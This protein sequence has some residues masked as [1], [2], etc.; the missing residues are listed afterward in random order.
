MDMVR[1]ISANRHLLPTFRLGERQ[2]SYALRKMAL[3]DSLPE[4]RWSK[5]SDKASP[6]SWDNIGQTNDI[7]FSPSFPGSAKP[8]RETIDK[9]S[10]SLITLASCHEFSASPF[11]FMFQYHAFSFK[12]SQQSPNA[13]SLCILLS[14]Q[15]LGAGSSLPNKGTQKRPILVRSDTE[16]VR[17]I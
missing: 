13:L 14:L 2:Q 3:M 16:R 10:L 12:P 8:S 9:I 7:S 5:E 4:N 6:V 11:A 17:I 1:R 15:L